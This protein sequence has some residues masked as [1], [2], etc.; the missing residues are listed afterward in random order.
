MKEN[1][2]A[3]NESI[4]PPPKCGASCSCFFQRTDRLC[5]AATAVLTF[6]VYLFT[7]APNVT[8]GFSGIFSVG[9][10]Y[11]G[12]AHPPGYPLW[13]CYAWVFTKLLPFGNVAWRV[14]LSSA[15]A[16]ALACGLIAL[17]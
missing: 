2:P 17:L 1:P 4:C 3:E 7:L 16:S 15:T 13:T 10:M 12:V 5:C 14:A 6:A 11:G 9:A 8:L